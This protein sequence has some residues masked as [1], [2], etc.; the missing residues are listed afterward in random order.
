MLAFNLVAVTAV[1]LPYKVFSDYLW[2]IISI[3]LVTT[4]TITQ[5]CICFI[6]CT[7]GSSPKLQNF[8]ITIKLG[9]DGVPIIKLASK[10][11]PESD[12]ELESNE[13]LYDQEDLD[14]K[15]VRRD[16]MEEYNERG[17]NEIV[18]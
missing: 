16:S 12:P 8:T 15:L 4:D 14:P 6:C 2:A 5:I 13:T 11:I 9:T 17:A 1:S 7:M 3:I 18:M 10:L